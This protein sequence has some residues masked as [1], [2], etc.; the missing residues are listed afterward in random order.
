M[1]RVANRMYSTRSRPIPPLATTSAIG[2][3]KGPPRIARANT[4]ASRK[5]THERMGSRAHNASYPA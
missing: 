1:W 3:S 4:Q 2:H 5:Q